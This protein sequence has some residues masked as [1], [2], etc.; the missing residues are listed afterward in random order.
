MPTQWTRALFP[1]KTTPCILAL[2]TC[3]LSPVSLVLL[4]SVALSPTSALLS[5]TLLLVPWFCHP[6]LIF[7]ASARATKLSRVLATSSK[8]RSCAAAVPRLQA[9]VLAVAPLPAALHTPAQALAPALTQV[10]L[11][12]LLFPLSLSSVPLPRSSPR[13]PKLMIST[14]RKRVEDD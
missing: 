3:L 13:S 5:S 2:S 11:A 10:L 4:S 1:S 14:S 7:P 6:P 9:A 8:D 12:A